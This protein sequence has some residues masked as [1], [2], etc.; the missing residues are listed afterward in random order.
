MRKEDKFRK[1]QSSHIDPRHPI[2]K[3]DGR[4][5]VVQ[6]AEISLNITNIA[7]A[8]LD[9]IPAVESRVLV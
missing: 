7:N 2:T 1:G 9:V 8:Y 3:T 5:I 6:G 4:A